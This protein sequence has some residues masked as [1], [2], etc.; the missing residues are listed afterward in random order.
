MFVALVAEI[1]RLSVAVTSAVNDPSV[2]YVWIAVH[3]V[4]DEPSPK[5]Q[6]QDT[7]ETPPSI[8]AVKLTETFT[9]V[10]FGLA[11]ALTAS[12]TLT[13]ND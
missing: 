4:P 12:L 8:G 6:L 11:S 2:A 1:L 7:G 9:S 5:F 3:P 10:G 13:T